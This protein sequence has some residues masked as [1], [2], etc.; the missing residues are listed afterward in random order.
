MICIKERWREYPLNRN[1]FVSDCGRVKNRKGK[2][3]S[4][5]KS[6]NGYLFISA[7]INGKKETTLVHRMVMIAFCYDDEW[8]IKQVNHKNGIRTD[9]R[10]CN[11]E[12][13]YAKENIDEKCIK[14]RKLYRLLQD[15]IK[16]LGYEETE[17]EL[18]SLL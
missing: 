8:N 16:Q 17:K 9:N 1:Y 13:V 15:V 18:K 14:Q 11:L 4:L 7:S 10:L 12:W 2:I 3:L 6:N 5:K